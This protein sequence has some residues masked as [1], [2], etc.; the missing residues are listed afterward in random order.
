MVILGG[1]LSLSSV[2]DNEISNGI[3][4]VPGSGAEIVA[5]YLY[6]YTS[7]ASIVISYTPAK[8]IRVIPVVEP[9]LPNVISLILSPL[10]NARI[11][12]II[13]SPDHLISTRLSLPAHTDLIVTLTFPG[14]S[15][16]KQG[17]LLIGILPL[18]LYLLDAARNPENH[19][20]SYPSITGFIVG[21]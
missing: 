10:D 5:V 18:A 1:V 12:S 4:S 14:A 19:S 20:G 8:L 21:V 16:R 7:I 2:P 11:F 9:L 3:I 17:S 13:R 15:G 6:P